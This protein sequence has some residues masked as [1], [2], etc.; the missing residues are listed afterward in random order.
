MLLLLDYI[1]L[2][3]MALRYQCIVLKIMIHWE[4]TT[5]SQSTLMAS[6]KWQHLEETFEANS[7]L[8]ELATEVLSSDRTPSKQVLCVG[9]PWGDVLQIKEIIML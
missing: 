6:W 2:S 3:C 8:R 7:L 1:L 9:G 5:Y 4:D